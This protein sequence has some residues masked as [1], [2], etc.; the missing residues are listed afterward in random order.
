MLKRNVS[1]LRKSP[2]IQLTDQDIVALKA[3]IAAIKAD[4]SKFIFNDG[5]HTCYIDA[6]DKIIVCGDVFPDDVY[7]RH[8]RDMMSARAVLAHEYYGHRV[9]RGTHLDSGSWNDEFRAS[10]SAARNAPGL[11]EKDRM[12]L[13]LDAMERAKDA[14]VTIRWNSFMR[15]VVYGIDYE[16][17]EPE[18]EAD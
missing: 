3:D 16:Q 12:W 9:N 11:T 8:P 7:S 14:G 18:T 1:G 5:S 6:I 13:V 15:S 2:L 17:A 4:E 10:Y